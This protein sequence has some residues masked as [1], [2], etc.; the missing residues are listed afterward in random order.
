M[1][2]LGTPHVTVAFLVGLC[3]KEIKLFSVLQIIFKFRFS[4]HLR[5]FQG[6]TIVFQ[7]AKL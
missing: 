2:P 5:L 7:V 3:S 6:V 4:D 1:D